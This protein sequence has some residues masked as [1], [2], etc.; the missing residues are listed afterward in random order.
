MNNV[1]DGDGVPDAM[2]VDRFRIGLNADHV[3]RFCP[4]RQE[5]VVCTGDELVW[6]AS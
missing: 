1:M 6:F 5:L 3:K 2:I 4:V